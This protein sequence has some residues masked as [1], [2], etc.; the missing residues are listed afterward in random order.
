MFPLSLLMDI[1]LDS[2]LIIRD[3]KY[4]IEEMKTNLTTGEVDLTL[5]SYLVNPSDTVISGGS[6]SVSDTSAEPVVASIPINENNQGVKQ[7]Y[8]TIGVPGETQFVTT[9]PTLPTTITTSTN[10]EFAVPDNVSGLERTNTIPIVYY[11]LDG[12]EQFTEYVVITQDSGKA[13]LTGGGSQLLTNTFNNL[14]E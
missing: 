3:K 13:Y 10:F 1:T 2:K 8:A 6:G 14:T 7:G 12:T 9:T 5:L 4:I 11:S